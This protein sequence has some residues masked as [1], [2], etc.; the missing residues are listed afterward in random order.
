MNVQVSHEI[1]A[2]GIASAPL[3]F[4]FPLGQ[5]TINTTVMGDARNIAAVSIMFG[6]MAM[7]SVTLTQAFPTATIPYDMMI[8][9]MTIQKGATFTLTVPLANQLG[10]VFFQATIVTPLST[11]PFASPVASWSLTS[12]S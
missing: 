5:A 11:Q 8:G 10:M 6:S 4:G 1:S 2:E 3:T 9:N 7:Y 12:S